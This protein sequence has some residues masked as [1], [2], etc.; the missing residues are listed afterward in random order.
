MR[1]QAAHAPYATPTTHK[2][3]VFQSVRACVRLQLFFVGS[4]SISFRWIL[5]EALAILGSQNVY[6]SSTNVLPKF[7]QSSTTSLRKVHHSTL[8]APR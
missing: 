2:T 7:H 4:S 3:K 1:R 6:N 5:M 8:K